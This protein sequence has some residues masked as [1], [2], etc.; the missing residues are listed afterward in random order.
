LSNLSS[1]EDIFLN[2][3]A[4]EKAIMEKFFPKSLERDLANIQLYTN[5]IQEEECEAVCPCCG[6]NLIVFEF[7]DEFIWHP[8]NEF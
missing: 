1:R 3:Y 2:N 4:R 6:G 7:K 5:E 8:S